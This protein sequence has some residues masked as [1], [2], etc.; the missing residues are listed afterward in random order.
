MFVKERNFGNPNT[1]FSTRLKEN[2]GKDYYDK[3]FF[4][5]EKNSLVT[6]RKYHINPQFLEWHRDCIFNK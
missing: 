6:P 4:P 2:V 1:T 3:Y 5:V